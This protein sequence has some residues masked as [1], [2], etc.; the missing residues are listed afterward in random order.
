MS[1]SVKTFSATVESSLDPVVPFKV[2]HDD[3]WS[4]SPCR[5]ERTSG[6]RCSPQLC[7]KEGKADADAGKM[8]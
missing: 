8:G 3:C 2:T 7:D 6:Q 5:I 1:K 4:E